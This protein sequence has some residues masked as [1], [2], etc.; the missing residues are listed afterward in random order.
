MTNHNN[1][2]SG[3]SQ[4]GKYIKNITVSDKFKRMMDEALIATRVV[5]ERRKNDL[6]IWGRAQQKEFTDKMGVKGDDIIIHKFIVCDVSRKK[7]LTVEEE[8]T[9]VIEFMRKAVDRMIVIINELHV[10]ERK[11]VPQYDENGREKAEEVY[12]YVSFVNKTFTSDFSAYVLSSRT[13]V[14]KPSQYSEGLEI[15]IG[16]N[17]TTK[18]LMG[19]NSKVSTLC[20]EI[21][22]FNRVENESYKK[23]EYVDGKDQQKYRGSWGGVSTRDLP[24][25]KDHKHDGGYEKYRDILK[26]QHSIDVL[27][28][29]YNFEMYFEIE[30]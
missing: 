22:H 18:K 9:T 17:F 28:N 14:I 13:Q 29:A 3:E 10:G 26:K 23:E 19:A 6:R 5:L 21:S 2:S 27:K 8:S 30:V 16:H 11:R 24:E 20:H 4:Q 7:E 15:N 25:G 12:K 1:R